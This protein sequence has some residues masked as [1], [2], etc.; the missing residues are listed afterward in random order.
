MKVRGALLCVACDTPAARKISGFLSFKANF[1]CTRC[2]S[3][4]GTGTFGKQDFSGF[5]CDKWVP[6]SVKQHRKDIDLCSTKTARE[7]KESEVGCRYSCLLQ[8]PYFDPVKMTIIDPMHNL[9][10]GTA[11]RVWSNFRKL[12][13]ITDADIVIINSKLSSFRIPSNVN[14]SSLPEFGSSTF[15][16]EQWMIWVNY[17]SVFCLHGLLDKQYIECWRS[18]VLASRLLCKSVLSKDDIT[19]AKCLLV[20]FCRRFEVL[21]GK[22]EVTPNMHMQC[23]MAECVHDFGPIASFW[24]FS[25]E[26]FNGLLGDLPTNNRSIELQVMKRFI[27]DNSHFQL[28]SYSPTDQA[29]SCLF[30]KTVVDHAFQFYSTKHLDDHVSLNVS[31]LSTGFKY[32]PAKKYTLAAFQLESVKCLYPNLY[33]TL[34]AESVSIAQTYR[35]MMSVTI[36]DQVFCGGQYALAN[37]SCTLK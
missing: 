22:S 1:G 15:T 3:N 26:R 29:G 6:R 9:Y 33:P 25:F 28:L 30:R 2:Y 36:N 24:C 12:H 17:Y 34:I 32:T 16:A 10:L 4:F 5:D 7:H 31:R 13:L 37:S 14:F 21:Y 35:K 18:F 20:H 8:L 23:H 27:S 19:I 11:K